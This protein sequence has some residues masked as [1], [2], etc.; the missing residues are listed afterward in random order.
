MRATDPTPPRQKGA[1]A[2][3]SV[4]WNRGRPPRARRKG[5]A[6]LPRCSA[7]LVRDESK[8]QKT[9]NGHNA[10]PT[11]RQLRAAQRRRQRSTRVGLSGGRSTCGDVRGG[12]ND[13]KKN[14]RIDECVRRF[15]PVHLEILEMICG[16]GHR[17]HLDRPAPGRNTPRSQARPHTTFPLK[18]RTS[19]TYA[20]WACAVRARSAP[21]TFAAST[22]SS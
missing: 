20:A 10:L 2:R 9:N 18:I 14:A 12:Y 17:Q 1:R 16:V 3:P 15:S 11:A 7:V 13:T 5:S 19:A 8:R 22:P 6:A 4:Q 21:D